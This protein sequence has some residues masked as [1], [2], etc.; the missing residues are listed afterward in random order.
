MAPVAASVPAT[1]SSESRKERRDDQSGL[2]E[3]DQKQDQID[4]DAVVAHQPLQVT[5]EMQHDIEEG[6]EKLQ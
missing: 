1:N 4:P 5:V 6:G 2:A 3:D